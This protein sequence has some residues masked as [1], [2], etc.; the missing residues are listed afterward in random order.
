MNQVRFRPAELDK[1]TGGG[2]KWLGYV[3]VGILDWEDRSDKYDWADV[4]LVATLSIK[5][6]QYPH[7][8]RIA[9]SFD[10]EPNG[11]IKTCTLLKRLY[12]LFDVIGFAGGPNVRGEMVD[13]SGNS[14]ILVDYLNRN[15][16]TSPVEPKHEFLGYRYKEQA[17]NDPNKTYHTM[18]PRLAP[19]TV[20]GRKDLEGYINFMKTK[21]FLKEAVEGAS[22]TNGVNPSSDT[23]DSF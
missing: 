8:M 12:N 2:S 1:T 23:V 18:F 11:E 17:K 16:V 9:G 10:K 20:D 13:E 6:S 3:P 15:H 14:I 4:F 19:N 21:G 5:D 22:T 7:E